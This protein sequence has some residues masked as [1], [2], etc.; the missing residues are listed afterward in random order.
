M[1][2]VWDALDLS[3]N[4]RRGLGAIRN[5]TGLTAGIMAAITFL[6]ALLSGA[7][8]WK[9]DI[10]ST[11]DATATV[12]ASVSASLPA[13]AVSL[14][15]LIVLA[16]T[17]SPTLMEL[18]GATFAKA[19]LLPFQWAVVGLSIFDLFT[20]AP[21]TTEFM[22]QWSWA[23]FGIFEWPAYAIGWLLWLGMSSFFFEMVAI[24]SIVVTVALALRAMSR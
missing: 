10:L 12:A 21:A 7:L 4:L 8:A 15:P 22:N 20:D 9:Y 1:D 19:E 16:L 14:A 13:S 23:S 5:A 18:G 24:V 6:I 2:R 17:F 11:I 3:E